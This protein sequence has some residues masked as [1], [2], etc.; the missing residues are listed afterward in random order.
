MLMVADTEAAV[1]AFTANP[2]TLAHS[3]P[4]AMSV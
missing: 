2:G 3:D 1:R 4:G